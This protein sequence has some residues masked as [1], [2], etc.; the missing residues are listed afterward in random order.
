MRL[1]AL[2]VLLLAI[3]T[4]AQVQVQG[5]SSLYEGQ[6]VS[7][8][9]LIANPHRNLEPLRSIPLQKAGQPYSGAEIEASIQALQEVGHFPKVT[10]NI[11]PDLS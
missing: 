5:P 4:W 7:A 6:H 1:S 10:V 2:L 9:A 11:V 8:V 3:F